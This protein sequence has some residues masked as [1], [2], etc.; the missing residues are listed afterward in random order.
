MHRFVVIKTLEKSFY[1][2]GFFKH[3]KSAV[4]AVDQVSFG[5]EKN[6]VFGLVGESGCGKTSLVRSILYLDPP[7]AGE[8]WIDNTLLGELKTT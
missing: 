2:H 3:L 8:V 6:S 5:I 7:T 4:K 1:G